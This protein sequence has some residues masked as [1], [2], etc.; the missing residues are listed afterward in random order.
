MAPRGFQPFPRDRG[1]RAAGCAR[2]SAIPHLAGNGERRERGINDMYSN[3]TTE[4]GATEFAPRLKTIA[5]RKPGPVRLTRA[6][7]Y[8]YGCCCC[9]RAL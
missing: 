8:C 7:V 4:S 6:A 2:L 1:N 9:V 3:T 5:V